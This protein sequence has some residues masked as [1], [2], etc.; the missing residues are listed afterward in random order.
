MLKGDYL[1]A[2]VKSD[3]TVFI[4][5]VVYDIWFILQN[6]F[7]INKAIVEA[8]IGLSFIQLLDICVRQLEKLNNLFSPINLAGI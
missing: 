5:G 1:S 4:F 2:I 6:R 8:R 7:P 3:Q